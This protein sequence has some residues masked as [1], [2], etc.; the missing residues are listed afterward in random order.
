[1]F[2][3]GVY[4]KD[5]NTPSDFYGAGMGKL[6]ALFDLNGN[7]SEVFFLIYIFSGPLPR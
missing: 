6:P 2:R 1:M 5:K 7:A 3:R 4:E